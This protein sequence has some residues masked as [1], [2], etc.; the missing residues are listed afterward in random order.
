MRRF[1]IFHVDSS[2]ELGCR[3]RQLAYLACALRER[4][5]RNVVVCR[6]GSALSGLAA[7]RGLEVRHLP[8][9]FGRDP[10]S[11]GR[12]G[13]WARGAENPVLHAHTQD[14]VPTAALA[15]ALGGRAVGVSLRAIPVDRVEAGWAG[16]SPERFRP[17]PTWEERKA[18]RYKLMNERAGGQYGL[19]PWIGCASALIPGRG[20]DILIAAAAVVIMECPKAT[21]IF[22]GQGPERERL[23]AQIKRLRILGK[24]LLLDTPRD[25][26]ELLKCLDVFVPG[27]DRGDDE[28]NLL[29]AIACGAPIAGPAAGQVPA[30]VKDRETALLCPPGDAEVLARTILASIADQHLARRLA[31]NALKEL[32]RFGLTSLADQ[33]EK[34]YE[35][36]A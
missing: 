19:E 36:V 29:E 1:T 18:L 3:E 14:A 4:G 7:A 25:R 27:G 2:R 17:P 8:F 16:V 5:H 15:T 21:F 33:A 24:V 6:S 9:L 23:L 34:I 31:L 13:L 10:L 30:F 22:T 26:T 11:A 12:L 20:L 35:A 28:E 32:P